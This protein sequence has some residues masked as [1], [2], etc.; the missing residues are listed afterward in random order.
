MPQPL[1]RDEITRQETGGY[2]AEPVADQVFRGNRQAAA[3][4][5]GRPGYGQNQAA[6]E[7]SADAPAEQETFGERT[8]KIGAAFA[9]KVALATEV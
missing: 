7:C 4:E 2:H 5:A 6:D 3:D 9:K 1:D 8:T